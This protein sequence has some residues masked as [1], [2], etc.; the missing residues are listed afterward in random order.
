[1]TNI[2]HYL[3][4][5]EILEEL[6]DKTRAIAGFRRLLFNLR[7]N[8][9]EDYLVGSREMARLLH[10]RNDIQGAKDAIEQAVNKFPQ[11]THTGGQFFLGWKG[12]QVIFLISRFFRAFCG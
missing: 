6:G 4:R 3:K 8:Q 12:E 7:P 1:M 9:G 2:E 11:F 10:S 5:T